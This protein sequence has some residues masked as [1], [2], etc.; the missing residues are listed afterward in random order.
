M[1]RICTLVRK[2]FKE[3]DNAAAVAGKLNVKTNKRSFQG[4]LN[5]QSPTSNSFFHIAWTTLK[6]QGHYSKVKGHIR[7]TP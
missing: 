3:D 7:V 5:Y 1:I 4:T 2:I 6:D